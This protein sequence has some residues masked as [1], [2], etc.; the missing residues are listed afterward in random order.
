[1]SSQSNF[2][3]IPPPA[4]SALIALISTFAE[5]WMSHPIYDA[6]HD[7]THIRRVLS[8]SLHLHS[9][10]SI[11]D[12]P[13]YNRT[14]IVLAALLHDCADRKYYPALCARANIAE[15]LPLTKS[16]QINPENLAKAILDHHGAA[17]ELAEAVQE[18][19]NG[20]SYSAETA[21]PNRTQLTLERHPELAIVRMQ[22]GWMPSAPS[23]LQGRSR[24][25][26]RCRGGCQP[27]LLKMDPRLGMM[28]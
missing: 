10:E 21:N 18:V 15:L 28:Y 25:A 12:C 20:M 7:W 26:V 23:G 17:P 27:L 16:E 19:I 6:S 11:H 13:P 2:P 1:M 8:L 3:A 9:I 24:T 14:I 5:K 4:D 22:I